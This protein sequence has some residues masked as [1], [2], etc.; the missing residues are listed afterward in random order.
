M[1]AQ[2]A[3]GVRGPSELLPRHLRRRHLGASPPPQLPVE[4]PHR[5]GD[6]RA[7]RPRHR[8]KSAT[9]RTTEF[10]G[11][12]HRPRAAAYP[13]AAAPRTQSPRR[14]APAARIPATGQSC[15]G[16]GGGRQCP[17]AE[18]REGL[19]SINGGA[20][21]CGSSVEAPHG[22]GNIFLDA[23]PRQE[24]RAEQIQRRRM[25]LE[26]R[27]RQAAPSGRRRNINGS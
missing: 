5:V 17:V 16:G 6:L 23:V 13:S 25:Q 27:V 7:C 22:R 19:I 2:I 26:R 4:L 14:R 9:H 15:G 10:T 18:R 24:H 21:L 11:G 12:H 20:D 8:I 3:A 1:Q